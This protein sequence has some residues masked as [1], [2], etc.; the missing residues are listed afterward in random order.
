MNVKLCIFTLISLLSIS[1][2]GQDGRYSEMFEIADNEFDRIAA[3]AASATDEELSNQMFELTNPA[4]LGLNDVTFVSE[5]EIQC[6][7]IITL[8]LKLQTKEAKRVI[9]RKARKRL[10]NNL[11]ALKLDLEC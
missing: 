10:L 7:Q 9:K 11:Q 6:T 3:E 1:A 4:N 5:K 2:F 8:Q